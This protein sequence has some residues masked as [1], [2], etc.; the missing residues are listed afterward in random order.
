MNS[1]EMILRTLRLLS[2]TALQGMKQKEQVDLMDKAGYGPT[3]IADMLGSTPN[4]IS[5]RL[6]EARRAR[7]SYTPA[8]K[9]KK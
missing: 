3:E 5:V 7:K 6:A 2:L 9:A 1:D 8:K 4:T